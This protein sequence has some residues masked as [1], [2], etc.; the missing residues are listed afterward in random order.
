M[1]NG[2]K[3][4]VNICYFA[5]S[6]DGWTIRRASD[7]QKISIQ[8]SMKKSFCWT[9]GFLPNPVQLLRNRPHHHHHHHCFDDRELGLASS[10]LV[11]FFYSF[12]HKWYG[13]SQ[14]TQL[15]KNFAPVMPNHQGG[16]RPPRLTWDWAGMHDTHSLDI[17]TE[18]WGPVR[19][20]NDDLFCQMSEQI[21]K[22]IINLQQKTCK[23]KSNKNNKIQN[24]AQSKYKHLLTFLIRH[25]V[26]IATKPMHQVQICQIVH[27]HR[28]PPTIPP[29]LHP[30]PCSSVGMQRWTDRHTDDSDHYTFHLSY[31]LCE[32]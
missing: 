11:F 23:D 12:R 17:A 30:G 16:N 19:A 14:A 27:N 18:K 28:A 6:A 31:A 20:N 15:Y 13:F 7:V 32:M 10:I 26:V 4:V 2:C 9:S 29:N 8:Q 21:F 1:Y 24:Q 22:D 25:Y 3:M 5:Y